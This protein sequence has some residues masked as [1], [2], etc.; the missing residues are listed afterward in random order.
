MAFSR[1]SRFSQNAPSSMFDRVLNTRLF[2]TL[3][4]CWFKNPEIW[5]SGDFWVRKARTW[6][7]KQKLSVTGKCPP[8]TSRKWNLKCWIIAE[9]VILTRTLMLFCAPGSLWWWQERN[10]KKLAIYVLDYFFPKNS[11]FLTYWT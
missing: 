1:C 3:T 9:M 10:C 2:S 11:W 5:L 6:I 7:S 8:P 4:N